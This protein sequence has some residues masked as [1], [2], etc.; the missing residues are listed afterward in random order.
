MEFV[1]DGKNI[2]YDLSIE[3]YK[4]F[5]LSWMKLHVDF[6]WILTYLFYSNFGKIFWLSEIT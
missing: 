1:G 2:Y 6:D 3:K 5:F 4:L